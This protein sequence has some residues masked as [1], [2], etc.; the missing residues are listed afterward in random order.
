MLL[1]LV[2]ALLLGYVWFHGLTNSHAG[3]A[4]LYPDPSLTPGDVIPGI[5]ADDVCT[6]Y[7]TKRVR[8]VS[9]SE[10]DQVYKNYQTANVSKQHEL[11]HLFS[12]ELGGSNSPKNLWPEPYE[13]RPGAHEK[14]RVENYLH[15]QVCNGSMTLQEAQRKIAT[16]WYAIYLTLP[17]KR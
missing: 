8:S 7:Y 16:D 12:L 11:D 4:S 17:A 1:L 13:P 6:P 5:T 2:F 10:R 9:E 15:R 3:D 14:D